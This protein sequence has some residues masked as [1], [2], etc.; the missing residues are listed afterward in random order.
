MYNR[1]LLRHAEPC[2]APQK[3]DARKTDD[4]DRGRF[5]APAVR[6]RIDPAQKTPRRFRGAVAAA[7]CLVLF[8]GCAS[9]LPSTKSTVKSPWVSFDKAKATYEQIV[10]GKTTVD[11]L[12]KL[13]FD[14]FLASNVRIMTATE[15][16]NHFMP[17]PSIRLDDLDA[18]IQKCIRGKALCSGYQILPSIRES[19]RVG[20]FWLDLFGFKRETIFTGWEFRGLLTILDS[21]VTYK[22]PAGGHPMIDTEQVEIKPLGPLQEI[23]NILIGFVA[24]PI[25]P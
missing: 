21:V 11:D 14:P 19:H 25:L 24:T 20:N 6:R 1:Q 18:G 2:I 5:L 3:D 15:V 22:D 8:S 9:L 17:N 4:E 12:K 16:I 10:P 23:G 7:L 13:G